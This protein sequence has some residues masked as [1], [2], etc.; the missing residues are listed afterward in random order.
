MG[1]GED[2]VA[3]GLG[4]L[5][6]IDLIRVTEDILAFAGTLLPGGLSSLLAI[7]LASAL[8]LGAELDHLITYDRVMTAFAG[9]QGIHAFAPADTVAGADALYFRDK[10]PGPS[11]LE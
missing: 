11:P 8:K 9:R 1:K 7:H 6:R 5:A 3:R 10:W 4:V 2:A